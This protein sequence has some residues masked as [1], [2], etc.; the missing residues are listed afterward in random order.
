MTTRL[1]AVLLVLSLVPSSLPNTMAVGPAFAAQDIRSLTVARDPQGQLWA[2]WEADTGSDVEI[3]FSRSSGSAWSAPEPVRVRSDAW[4]HSPSLAV[5]AAPGS[6]SQVWLAWTSSFKSESSRREL[7]V[8]R[9][10]AGAWTEP[11]AVPIGAVTRVTAPTLAASADGTVWLAWTAFDG[12]DLEVYASRWTGRSWSTPWQ[13]SAD[14]GKTP[15]DDYYPRLIVAGDGRPWLVWVGYHSGPDD[16]LYASH[17]TGTS[18]TAEQMVNRDDDSLDSLPSLALGPDS[19]PWLAWMARVDGGEHSHRRILFAHW[20]PS[21]LAWTP[22]QLASSSP[23]LPIDEDM[24]SLTLDGQGQMHLAWIASAYGATTLAHALWTGANWSQAQAIHTGV[25]TDVLAVE[26]GNGRPAFLWL[27]RSASPAPVAQ[28]TAGAAAQSLMAWIDSHPAPAVVLS[29]P[30]ANRYL[31][32]GDSITWGEYEEN[33]G[34]SYPTRLEYKLD[35]RVRPSEVLN[36]GEPG[37]RTA[38]GAAR[39]GPV[40][41]DNRPKYV[42]IMEGTNDVSDG[43]G[44][45]VVYD[46]LLDMIYNARHAGVTDVR[47]VMATIIPRNDNRNDET[48]TM[49]EE[50]VIPAASLRNISV[51]QMYQAFENYG[52]WSQLIWDDVHPNGLGL[53]LMADTWYNCILTMFNEIYEDTTPPTP[54]LGSVPPQTECLGSVAVTW[55]GVDNQGGTGVADFDV[56][57]QVDTGW[58]TDWLVATTATSSWY[59]NLA[60][61]HTYSFRVRARDLAGN[62]SSYTAPGSTQVKDSTPPYEA[63]MAALPPARLAPFTVYWGGSDACSGVTAYDVEYNVDGGAWQPWLAGTSSTSGSFNPGSPQYGHTYFFHAR[64][65]DLAG[66]TGAWSAAVSIALARWTLGGKIATVRDAPITGALVTLNPA[67][68]AVEPT[69]GGYLAYLPGDGPYD[70]WAGRAGFGPLPVMLDV[71][72][73]GNMS[74]VDL[75]LPPLDDAVTD[76]GFESGN[77]TAWQTGGTAPPTLAAAAHTGT[78]SVQMG[79]GIG[80]S[81]IS[82]VVSPALGPNLAVSNPTL[83]FLVRL[84]QPGSP[85]SL[86]IALSGSSPATFDLPVQSEAWSHIWYDL[87]GLMAGPMTVT[88]SVSGDPSVLIDEISIGSAAH[89]AY[90]AYLP[91]VTRGW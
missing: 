13:V 4:D 18:W 55:S 32:F 53:Q 87:T 34:A 78:H 42:L 81:T 40:V 51:C 70:V 11:Q 7:Y 27:D 45:G 54:T 47:L 79:D 67:A 56:Q 17:W 59:P 76:G 15:R 57:V 73:A 6:Q 28:T 39:I 36:F 82:Q 89:G 20:N 63:H 14:D 23:D 77:L 22:E 71:A 90:R 2:A 50:A 48:Q 5:A 65:H 8:S 33:G 61:G 16:D 58:W 25:N 66:N 44:P 24:P 30:I 1:L 19:Q 62:M 35:S 83:S 43:R 49:N 26:S 84:E 72:V 91:I 46:H 88:F 38:Q 52:D 31:G 75:F 68:L 3:Y 74:S 9:W 69:P 64:A 21:R 29:D 41:S 37:E 60:W 85:S 86:H 80:S 12:A 10:A